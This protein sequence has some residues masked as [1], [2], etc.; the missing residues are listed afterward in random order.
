MQRGY[1]RHPQKYFF[2]VLFWR[3]T[4]TPAHTGH[5]TADAG[6]FVDGVD[7]SG[8]GCTGIC[9]GGVGTKL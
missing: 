8:G 6:G 5:V 9:D 4:I 7:G 1:W 2:V 3:V